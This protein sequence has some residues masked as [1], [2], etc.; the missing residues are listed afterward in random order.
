MEE[1]EREEEKERAEKKKDDFSPPLQFCT[2]R[3]DLQIFLWG[4]FRHFDWG[5]QFSGEKERERERA[6]HVSGFNRLR[7][8][9][10]SPSPSLLSLSR[11][12]SRA[13]LARHLGV[14]LSLSHYGF[15]RIHS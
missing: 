6:V 3:R 11:L 14:T 1:R 13:D 5:F 7:F 2:N 10:A 4:L 15:K 9:H 8:V 12:A